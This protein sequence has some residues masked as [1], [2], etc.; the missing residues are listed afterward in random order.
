[1]IVPI[2]NVHSVILAKHAYSYP[3]CQLCCECCFVVV[4]YWVRVVVFVVKVVV[5]VHG[6]GHGV[7]VSAGVV[8]L[9]VVTAM[10]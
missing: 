4:V 9:F 10:L 2:C 5:V 8:S 6:A 1:M 7:F 3:F